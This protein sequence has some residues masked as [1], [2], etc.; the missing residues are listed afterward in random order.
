MNMSMVAPL[1]VTM[2]V[3]ALDWFQHVAR[4]TRPAAGAQRLGAGLVIVLTD[5]PVSPSLA[6]PPSRANN[7]VWLLESRFRNEF[8]P[9]MISTPKPETPGGSAAPQ[10]ATGMLLTSAGLLGSRWP[11]MTMSGLPP[12][13]D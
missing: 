5:S 4:A 13:P 3:L 6:G 1:P 12:L 2:L 7:S 11:P 9:R 8:P 10:P